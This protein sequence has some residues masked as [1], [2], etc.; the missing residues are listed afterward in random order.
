MWPNVLQKRSLWAVSRCERRGVIAKR[1]ISLMHRR[2]SQR[3][4]EF[5]AIKAL[6]SDNWPVRRVHSSC[7]MYVCGPLDEACWAHSWGGGRFV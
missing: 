3:G 4:T 2:E 5:V 1:I 7:S 6:M